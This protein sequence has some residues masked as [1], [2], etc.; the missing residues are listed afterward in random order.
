VYGKPVEK[1]ANFYVE[2]MKGSH[3]DN[4]DEQAVSN[5]ANFVSPLDDNP[6]AKYTTTPAG[7][8]TYIGTGEVPVLDPGNL[9]SPITYVGAG[10][11]VL[12]PGNVTPRRWSIANPIASN[13]GQ[14]EFVSEFDEPSTSQ[15][16]L[17]PSSPSLSMMQQ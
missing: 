3:A 14:I 7:T 6:F 12:D 10:M 15:V 11:P 13:E 4:D 8:V 17:S 2:S 9:I 1:S 16:Q 5:Y